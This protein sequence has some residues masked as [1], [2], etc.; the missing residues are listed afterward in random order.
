[1]QRAQICTAPRAASPFFPGIPLSGKPPSALKWRS[2]LEKN[3]GRKESTTRT[4][5]ERWPKTMAENE[6]TTRTMAEN[7]GE[8]AIGS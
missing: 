5:V 1:M 3:D 4:A 6:S 2:V 7:D 8:M